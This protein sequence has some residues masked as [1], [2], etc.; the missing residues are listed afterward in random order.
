MLKTRSVAKVYQLKLNVIRQIGFREKNFEGDLYEFFEQLL[1]FSAKTWVKR[2]FKRMLMF[3]LPR[4]AHVS[5]RK[6]QP[7]TFSHLIP[8]AHVTHQPRSTATIE[9]HSYHSPTMIKASPNFA[10]FSNQYHTTHLSLK[11]C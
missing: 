1:N 11:S 2:V 9:T 4:N 10:F 7:F 5:S 6:M 8:V 3:V